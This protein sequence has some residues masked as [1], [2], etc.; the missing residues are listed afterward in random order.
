MVTN[1]RRT[2]RALQGSVGL[3]L[4]AVVAMW[5][6][7]TP[8]SLRHP[9]FLALA[10]GRLAG[11]LAGV[12][13]VVLVLLMARITPLERRIGADHLTRLHS[14]LGRYTLLLLAIHVPLVVWG[15][16]GATR[17]QLLPEAIV[18]WRDYPYIWAAVAAGLLLVAVAVTS[19][20]RIRRRLDYETW[21][22]THLLTYVAIALAFGH[23]I[24]VG[25]DFIHNNLQ[26]HV[27]A[28]GYLAAAGVVGYWRVLRPI[29]RALRTRAEVGA[30]VV[31]PGGAVTLTVTG[32]HV[33]EL[34]ARPGQ[35]FRVRVLTKRLWSQSHPYSLSAAPDGRTLRFTIKPAV[36]LASD[37]R[38]LVPGTR[39]FIDGPF[40]TLT[41]ER[42]IRSDVLLIAGGIG[43]TPLR[44]LF[45]A[46]PPGV[47]DVT[48]IYRCRSE[49]DVLFRDE[50]DALATARGDRV[51]YV[52]GRTADL[53]DPLGASELE[54]LVPDIA[55]RDVFLCAPAP[56]MTQL[57]NTLQR[58][59]VPRDSVH[60]E[61]F[62]VVEDVTPG[63]RRA[64]GFALATLAVT[65]FLGVR[66]DL[67]QRGSQLVVLGP[68][69]ATGD[70]PSPATATDAAGNVVVSGPDERTLYSSVQVQI[71]VH[72]GKLVDVLPLSLPN[73]DARSRQLSAMAEPILRREALASGGNRI[74]V[75]TGATYTSGA[76]QQ[77]L[78]GALAHVPK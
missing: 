33:K 4:T 67:F 29:H 37:L 76:Y 45:E 16:A 28:A 73:R 35:F 60:W 71:V 26:R 75:V 74:D 1:P 55:N 18:L 30:V 56:M 70:Q 51:I 66:S 24:A 10:V 50:L 68:V 17:M 57:T 59:G 46:V 5:W 53:G 9:S 65:L 49:Q 34:A 13:S 3:V 39:V 72:N 11:L 2:V 31:E 14:R 19:A 27:W 64:L 12:L 52:V 40:G 8:T 43:I 48:L 32:T 21:Y 47:G 15:F 25:S 38:D 41:A 20:R 69:V 62:E 54:R 22:F 63:S 6:H 23:Q 36:D 42:R 77:S 61:S 44:A 7:H 58:L 78:Q